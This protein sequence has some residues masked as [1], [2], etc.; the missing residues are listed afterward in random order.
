MGDLR[1]DLRFFILKVEIVDII[2]G[3]SLMT[4]AL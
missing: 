3:A 4:K 2:P 1:M